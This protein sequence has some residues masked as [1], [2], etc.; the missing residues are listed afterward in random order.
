MSGGYFDENL[1]GLDELI[2]RQN[3]ESIRGLEAL[4]NGPKFIVERVVRTP[5]QEEK[6]RQALE[7]YRQE[8]GSTRQ[9]RLRPLQDDDEWPIAYKEAA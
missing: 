4:G 6:Y 2:A 1:E 5:E 3:D 8:M 7:R 9:A